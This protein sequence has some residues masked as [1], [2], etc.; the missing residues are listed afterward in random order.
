MD[1]TQ[2]E[3]KLQQISLC[4]RMHTQ[5]IG[6]L[7]VKISLKK[8]KPGKFALPYLKVYNKAT[9]IKKVQ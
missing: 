2:S 5:T 4:A 9:V 8:K 7:L 6:K 1:S 3:S